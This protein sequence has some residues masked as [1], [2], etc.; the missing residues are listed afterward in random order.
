MGLK[1]GTCGTG[2]ACENHLVGGQSEERNSLDL[3]PIAVVTDDHTFSGLSHS[4]LFF[5]GLET[6]SLK[7][8]LRAVLLLDALGEKLFLCFSPY[9]LVDPSSVC[10]TSPLCDT[11]TSPSYRDL[12][13]TLGPPT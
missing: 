10:K 2:V 3:F 9:S 5:C 11:P 4:H 12:V 13:T 6:G 8:V 7:W 1:P